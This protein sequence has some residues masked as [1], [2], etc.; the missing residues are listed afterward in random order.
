MKEQIKPLVE[1]AT[2]NIMGVKIVNQQLFADL[3]V[4]KCCEL[5][6]SSTNTKCIYTTFDKSQADCVKA[7]IIKFVKGYFND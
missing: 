6:E 4:K 5:I 7:E 1:Q 2:E 3:L